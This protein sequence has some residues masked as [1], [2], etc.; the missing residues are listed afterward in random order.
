MP[1]LRQRSPADRL[2]HVWI[3]P[4]AAGGAGT[5]ISLED[6][7]RGRQL[8]EESLSHRP[9]QSVACGKFRVRERRVR[10]G[11]SAREIDGRVRDR[12][13]QRFWKSGRQR[14]AERVAIAA[15]V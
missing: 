5:K 13:E 1:Q 4:L 9:P 11:V 3:A 15:G 12:L 8:L 2:Q 7:A 14:H 6:A 10:F